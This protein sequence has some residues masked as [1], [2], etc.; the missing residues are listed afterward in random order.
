[1]NMIEKFIC[2]HTILLFCIGLL[3]V[4]S[5]QCGERKCKEELN[6]TEV[7]CC[8]KIGQVSA[9]GSCCCKR[10]NDSF[11][12]HCGPFE[13]SYN[14]LAWWVAAIL[15]I[16]IS[17]VTIATFIVVKRC[18]CKKRQTTTTLTPQ[19]EILHLSDDHEI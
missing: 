1:M 6:G 10:V 17:G 12:G 5:M 15:I 9:I 18:L 19:P 11:V 2:V 16:A 14:G 7:Y 13:K 4:N 8:T 3:N